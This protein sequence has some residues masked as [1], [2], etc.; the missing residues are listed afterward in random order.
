MLPHGTEIPPGVSSVL[1][2][3]LDAIASNY[4]R[5]K[6]MVP[7]AEVGVSIKADAYGLGAV[8]IA[9][10]LAAQGCQRSRTWPAPRIHS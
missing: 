9:P 5:I 4:R 7:V 8:S 3:D 1:I 10:A 6:S 2:V